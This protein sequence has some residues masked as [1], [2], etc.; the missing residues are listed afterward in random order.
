M[1]RIDQ[2]KCIACGLCVKNCPLT[3]I[4]D[5]EKSEPPSIQ[6]DLCVDCNVCTRVCP[7]DAVQTI[8]VDR[9]NEA[10]C[11]HCVINCRIHL[12]NWGAC[13]RYLNME[14]TLI[15]RRPIL[16]PAPVDFEEKR[17]TVAL[18]RPLLTGVG[19]GTLYPNPN[20]APYIVGE[21]VEGLDVVTAVTE[22]PLR[23]LEVTDLPL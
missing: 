11:D 13:Q 12:G 4:T 16:I 18:S 7:V 1:H 3:A 6:E 19:A 9:E 15:R 23:Y 2:E 22:A 8:A 5:R 10:T 14:G 17:R 21:D 20:P